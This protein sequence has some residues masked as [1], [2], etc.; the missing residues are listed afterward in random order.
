MSDTD[1]HKTTDAAPA[2]RDYMGGRGGKA[3]WRRAE[4]RY[5]K[6]RLQSALAIAVQQWRA[7]MEVPINGG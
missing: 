2:R 5:V 1:Q 7:K 3:R 6:R 4:D